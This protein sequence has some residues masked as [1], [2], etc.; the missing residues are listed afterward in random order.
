MKYFLIVLSLLLVGVIY[1]QYQYYPNIDTQTDL[2][3][4]EMNAGEEINDVSS[5]LKSIRAYSE[6]IKRPLFSLNRKPPHIESK[7]VV[8]TF[9]AQELDDLI[10]FGVVVSKDTTY[11]IVGNGKNGETDQLKEG[12]LYRGWRVENIS[13]ESV[14]F[15][16]KDAQ[17]ELFLSPNE[18][19]K[20]SGLKAL[21]KTKNKKS[22]QKEFEY[23]SLFRSS[24]KKS[25]KKSP[26]TIQ[27]GK[28]QPQA[29]EKKTAPAREPISEADLEALYSE[30]G[31]EYHPED[32][33]GDDPFLDGHD[34]YHDD[35]DHYEE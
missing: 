28:P 14:K 17:Y 24:Q 29:V 1:Y 21:D 16:G 33:L 19:T 7:S 3:E 30:G 35:E 18:N 20:K 15:A 23:K 32:E 6:I 5:R 22:G 25:P 31:Y 9:N 13:S 34:D 8:A 2:A 26:I 10:L 11:A 12:R 27:L 4:Q